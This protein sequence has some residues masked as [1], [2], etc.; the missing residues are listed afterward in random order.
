MITSEQVLTTLISRIHFALP[1]T[2]DKNGHI[3][4]VYWKVNGLQVPVVRPPAGDDV[5]AQVPL[6]LRL[7]ESG[8]FA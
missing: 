1:S 4:E 2:P 7:V 5:T 8:D 3:K 6:D